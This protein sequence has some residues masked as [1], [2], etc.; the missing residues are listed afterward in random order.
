M[1]RLSVMHSPGNKHSFSFLVFTLGM[2]ALVAQ[3][4][5]FRTFMQTFSG[6]EIAV[7]IF[8]ASWLLWIIPGT[9][10]GVLL[11]RTKHWPAKL[12]VIVPAYI[13]ALL[14]QYQLLMGLNELTGTASYENMPFYRLVAGAFL[15][16]MPVSILTG[17]FFTLACAAGSGIYRHPVARIHALEALGSCGGAGITALLLYL[18]VCHETIILLASTVLVCASAWCRHRARRLIL[19]AL[20]ASAVLIALLAGGLGL[21]WNKANCRKQWA[22]LLPADDYTGHFSTARAPYLYGRTQGQFVV[23]GWG[24]V[25][26]ALPNREYGARIAACH[27]AQHPAAIRVAVV[28]NHGLSI[29]RQMLEFPQIESVAWLSP[30]PEYTS[31]LRSVLP[32]E[33]QLTSSALDA[34]AADA[35]EYFRSN[36]ERFDIIMLNL[37]DLTTLQLSRFA[38]R[39]FFGEARNALAPGGVLSLRISGGENFIGDELALLGAS[40]MATCAGLFKH[41]AMQPGEETWLYWSDG[42]VTSD[43]S[44][45]AGR[46]GG[47]DGIR[48]IIPPEVLEQMFPEDRIAKQFARYDSVKASAGGLLVNSDSRPAAMLHALGVELKNSGLG[49]VYTVLQA[50]DMAGP[51]VCLLLFMFLPVTRLLYRMSCQLEQRESAVD[52]M[53]LIFMGG[54]S[55][56]GLVLVGLFRLQA[57]HGS[58]FLFAALLSS[59]FMLG[60][61]A[62]NTLGARAEAGHVP[63]RTIGLI[64]LLGLTAAVAGAAFSAPLPLWIYAA[65]F[66]ILGTVFGAAVPYAASIIN[67]SGITIAG[68]GSAVEALDNTGAAAAGALTS[69][70]LL[71][72]GGIPFASLSLAAAA[73]AALALMMLPAVSAVRRRSTVGYLAAGC[74]WIGITGAILF[75]GVITRAAWQRTEPDPLPR[76][77]QAYSAGGKYVLQDVELKDG[78]NA[79]YA[80]LEDNSVVYLSSLFSPAISGYGGRIDLGVHLGDDGTLRSFEIVRSRETPKYIEFIRPWCS[81]LNGRNVFSNDLSQVD[82]VTGATLSTRAIRE[83]LDASGKAVAAEVYGRRIEAKP[84]T[85]TPN[86]YRMLVMILFFTAATLLRRRPSPWTRRIFLAAAAVITGF[87]LN[88]QY[89]FINI[90]YLLS[91]RL[92]SPGTAAFFIIVLV[93]LLVVFFGNVYCGYICPFGA[94]QD[95]FSAILPVRLRLQLTVR[96]I[97]LGRA[98]KYALLGL[99]LALFGLSGNDA[100]AAADPLQSFF[101]HSWATLSWFG[102]VLVLLSLV[103]PRFWCRCLCPSGA[104]L[105]LLNGFRLLRKITPP[106][107]PARCD[108]GVEHAAELDCLCCD[109]CRLPG[110]EAARPVKAAVTS[111]VLYASLI[112]AVLAFLVSGTPSILFNRTARLSG[113]IQEDAPPESIIRKVNVRRIKQQIME[114]RLSGREASYYRRLDDQPDANQ[115]AADGPLKTI[116]K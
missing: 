79:E 53:L 46:A 44:I 5:L 80:R 3:T 87:I 73:A 20:T 52:A 98:V 107:A 97:R 55:S 11:A 42:D 15:V 59:L 67:R 116:P 66:T 83:I 68:S 86:D 69:L 114:N 101:M 102:G 27:L 14:L 75:A 38:T 18:N 70:I 77:A 61:W 17:C 88:T 105:S 91:G 37:P 16:N 9:Q 60:L 57:E 115:Q 54:C 43:G 10:L 19:P 47:L 84:E 111:S 76:L 45:L 78:A 64:Q 103:I 21:S 6:S 40:S 29:A 109:R 58:L 104:F 49:P 99:L 31:K 26:E 48:E 39:E 50:I 23:L 62:G 112:A 65:S 89:S 2:Y 8:F 74:L 56:M 71:P 63:F 35:R 1:G 34:P 94:L 85:R 81:R 82:T 22:K 90:L 32:E 72:A 95:L 110:T 25:S 93:P 108:L 41:L 96:T 100:L 33:Y 24:S 106:I 113:S 4:V 7:G 28:G 30:D 51:Y 13:P 92:P 12:A 36:K